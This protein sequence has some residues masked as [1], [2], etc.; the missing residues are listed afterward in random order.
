MNH[1]TPHRYVGLAGNSTAT[2]SV[3]VGVEILHNQQP[4]LPRNDG[5]YRGRRYFLAPALHTALFVPF[6]K[7]VMAWTN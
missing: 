7:V 3:V 5:Q 6:C 2:S 4:G 1:L